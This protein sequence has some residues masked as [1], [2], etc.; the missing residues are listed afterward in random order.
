M[1]TQTKL[2]QLLDLVYELQNNSEGVSSDL[3]KIISNLVNHVENMI[4]FQDD[5]M[6]AW[7]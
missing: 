1:Q 4:D 6:E 7:K 2:N 5:L 3:E